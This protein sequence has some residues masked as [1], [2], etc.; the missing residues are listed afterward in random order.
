[1]YIFFIVIVRIKNEKS[2]KKIVI[3]FVEVF[4]IPANYSFIIVVMG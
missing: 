2:I 3:L 4:I 1:M